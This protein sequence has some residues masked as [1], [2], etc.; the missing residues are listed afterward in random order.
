MQTIHVSNAAPRLL[1]K[2][3]STA[4]VVPSETLITRLSPKMFRLI[5]SSLT[6]RIGTR[7]LQFRRRGPRAFNPEIFQGDETGGQC[8]HAFPWGGPFY[9]TSRTE[10]MVSLVAEEVVFPSLAQGG[11]SRTRIREFVQRKFLSSK[12]IE[13]IGQA[14]RT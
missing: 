12:S 10:R 2:N 4:G 6:R 14:V 13:D 8:G 9:L 7:W 5:P 1:L 3:A 11:A